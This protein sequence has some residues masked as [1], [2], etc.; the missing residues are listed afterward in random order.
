MMNTDEQITS[1]DYKADLIQD[2]LNWNPNYYLDWKNTPPTCTEDDVDLKGDEPSCPWGCY[3]WWWNGSD[4]KK[5]EGEHCSGRDYS[6]CDTAN[7]NRENCWI[8][9]NDYFGKCVDFVTNNLQGYE[10]DDPYVLC[11]CSKSVRPPS[12]YKRYVACWYCENHDCGSS[13]PETHMNI[14]SDPYEWW[15]AYLGK[16][17]YSSEGFADPQNYV[18]FFNV[19]AAREQMKAWI[20]QYFDD[21]CPRTLDQKICED[22]KN[23]LSNYDD[24]VYVIEDTVSDP[25]GIANKLVQSGGG[26][27]SI[28]VVNTEKFDP[29]KYAWNPNYNPWPP[30]DVKAAV[31]YCDK[32]NGAG[33]KAVASSS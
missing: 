27:F 9:L 21:I 25:A 28:T 8:K 2:R 12:Q 17:A 15:K 10:M 24:H 20:N 3:Y 33:C 16:P 5:I 1:D 4:Y 18:F 30:N 26:L 23:H 13:C 29:D 22:L 6:A 14:A 11:G 19:D 7:T 31:V 32:D